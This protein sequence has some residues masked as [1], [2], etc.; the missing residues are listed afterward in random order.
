MDVKVQNGRTSVIAPLAA[1]F[2]LLAGVQYVL[3]EAIAASAW[4]SPAYNYA[5][6]FISDLGNPVPGDVFDGRLINSP[7]NVD[8]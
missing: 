2:L 5:V 6:D 8:D 3:L 1:F 7:L 4:H